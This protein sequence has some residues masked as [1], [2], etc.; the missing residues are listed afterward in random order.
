[1]ITSE[2]NIKKKINYLN[3]NSPIKV[4][5]DKELKVQC[6]HCNGIYYAYEY[7]LEN[8]NNF[9]YISCKYN[10]TCNG[11]IIDWIEPER[12]D[13][14]EYYKKLK[15]SIKKSDFIFIP[16]DERTQ[17]FKGKNY[18]RLN[19]SAYNQINKYK[20]QRNRKNGKVNRRKQKVIC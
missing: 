13:K 14:A 16:C 7:K 8:I 11:T 19:G 5:Y 10:P 6:L 20:A 4:I 17:T 3:K 9:D 2:I 18:T 15:N 1:M 12:D